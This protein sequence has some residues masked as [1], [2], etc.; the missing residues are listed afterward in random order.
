MARAQ[1]LIEERW[2]SITHGIGAGLS[3]IGFYLLMSHAVQ[4]GDA[5]YI[6]SFSIYGASLF[7]LYLASTFYHGARSARAKHFLRICDHSSIY[8]LIV[9]TY[10]PFCLVTMPHAWGYFMMLIMWPLAALGI[11]F[12]IFYVGKYDF[13]STLIYLAMGWM[14]VIAI[15]PFVASLSWYGCCLVGLGGLFY[16]FGVVFYA[17]EKIPFHHVIWHL[18]VMSGSACHFFAI[19]LYVAHF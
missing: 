14:A 4:S 7:L 9:G 12:K 15:K 10:T 2:N 6:V 13:F 1:T 19:F 17:F 11:V 3:G 18:F 5:N 8:L 16:T